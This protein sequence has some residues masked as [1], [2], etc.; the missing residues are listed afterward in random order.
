VRGALL[1][2]SH[3]ADGLAERDDELIALA[4]EAA[5]RRDD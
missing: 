5:R 2:A 1:L 4:L 3:A